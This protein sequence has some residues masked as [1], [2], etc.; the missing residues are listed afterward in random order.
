MV[1]YSRFSSK[2]ERNSPP[3]PFKLVPKPCKKDYPKVLQRNRA[4]NEP[5]T[6]SPVR[7]TIEEVQR[8]IENLIRPYTQIHQ[9]RPIPFEFLT[10]KKHSCC[11]PRREL[12]SRT[13][14]IE[15]SQ[16][17]VQIA[18]KYRIPIYS[19]FFFKLSIPF[20]YEDWDQ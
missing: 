19:L 14:V 3:L 12:T 6:H 11:T 17:S 7:M 18:G 15:E 16:F 9:A 2:F 20:V 10:F 5:R 8:K 4:L 13:C 1:S